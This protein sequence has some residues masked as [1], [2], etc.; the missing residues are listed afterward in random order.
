MISLEHPP[1]FIAFTKND[2]IVTYQKNA[3]ERWEIPRQ[4]LEPIYR[5]HGI[6]DITK[7]EFILNGSFYGTN[8]TY[9]LCDSEQSFDI[10]TEMELKIVNRLL[11]E[12]NL[13]KWM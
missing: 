7:P 2:L 10:H 6:V 12:G 11:K 8:L 5:L 9:I 3:R 13:S 1:H 4:E